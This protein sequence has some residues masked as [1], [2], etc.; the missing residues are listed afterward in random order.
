MKNKFNVAG[1][2]VALTVFG[3]CAYG[4]GM[5]IV[6]IAQTDFAEL[7]GMII[8]RIVGIFLVPVGAIAGYL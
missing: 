4:W 1:A 8:V 7:S 6:R 2:A 3:F 5:N